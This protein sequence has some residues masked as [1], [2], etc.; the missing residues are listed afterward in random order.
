V[1]LTK[2][3]A[4]GVGYVLGARAGRERYE[5]VRILAGQAARWL[6][7]YGSGGSLATRHGEHRDNADAAA[8]PR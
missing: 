4:F 6:E 5:Q 7:A 1:I 2:L 3:G 8:R